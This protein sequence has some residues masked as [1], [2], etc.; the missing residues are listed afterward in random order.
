[1]NHHE[2]PGGLFVDF[3]ASRG[4]VICDTA[5]ILAALQT[6]AA[7]LHTCRERH[8]YKAVCRPMHQSAGPGRWHTFRQKLLDWMYCPPELP[9][10]AE[11]PALDRPWRCSNI[12]GSPSSEPAGNPCCSTQ[13]DHSGRTLKAWRCQYSI[14]ALDNCCTPCRYRTFLA[15]FLLIF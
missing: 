9:M 10:K 11:S 15:L 8:G 3:L 2:T 4:G 5:G 12:Y 13:R 14:P 1:V 6:P 7:P